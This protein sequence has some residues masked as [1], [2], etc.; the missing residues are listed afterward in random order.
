VNLLP[1]SLLVR[2]TLGQTI[3][4]KQ[5]TVVDWRVDQNGEV[6][7]SGPFYIDLV[8]DDVHVKR[9]AASGF[10]TGFFLRETDWAGLLAD[11]DLDSG[12]HTAKLIVD[13]TDLI[14]E[15]NEADNTVSATFS[16]AGSPRTAPPKT[17]K[18][19]NLAFVPS[20]D[21]PEPIVVAYDR[22]AVRTGTISADVP[23]LLSFGIDNAGVVSI[24]GR[25]IADLYI[26]QKF[27]DRF[28][29]DGM[30]SGQS[31]WVVWDELK[32][33]VTLSPGPHTVRVVAD[34]TS[35]VA[36]TD[37][38]DNTFEVTLVWGAGALPLATPT[39]APTP[40]IPPPR[41]EKTAPDLAPFVPFGWDGAIAARIFDMPG[42]VGVDQP[43]TTDRDAH[44]YFAFRNNSPISAG[45]SFRVVLSVDGQ[46]TWEN[47][48]RGSSADSG[49]VW[50]QK[51][52]VPA[53]KVTAGQHS[54][55][56]LLDADNQIAE[57]DETNN[58]F[59][60]QITWH[61]EAPPASPPP[62]TYTDAEL[63]SL[64]APLAGDLAL[65]T[66]NVGGARK[67][68]TDWTKAVLDIGEAGYYLLTGKSI[69]DE[70][71]EIHVLE[72]DKY[73]AA[74]LASCLS[75]TAPL[76]AA[77]YATRY[78][79]CRVLIGKSAGL[80]TRLDG[81]IHLFVDSEHTPVGVAGTL[82]HELGH[83]Y[84]DI[85]NPAQT[86]AL[87]S[88]TLKSLQE[89]EAQTFEAAAWR[90]VEE[91]LGVQLFRYPQLAAMSLRINRLLDRTV[92]EAAKNEEH[93]LGYLLMWLT[94]LADPGKLGTASALTAATRL[95]ATSTL[96]IF[97]YFV[98]L[99]PADVPAWAGALRANETALAAQYRA[100]VLKRT[101]AGLQ[102][103]QEGHPDLHG[104]AFLAP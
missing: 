47:S 39:P 16:W 18:L 46:A 84:Q 44:I 28:E 41:V 68:K 29:W 32:Q 63:K 7:A 35:S 10:G 53:G 23:A 13:A 97:N 3:T 15:S 75:N 14:R 57:S 4:S 36:E 74:V 79:E 86:E 12:P 26:D 70:R 98:M 77:E 34:P 54:V 85:R 95:N 83:A 52:V 93:Q 69:R 62:V 65:D 80:K 100:L 43:V 92:A 25:V 90:R 94:A 76:I 67:S 30:V 99:M 96:A 19:P 8:L 60:R 11:F 78:E 71:I 21:D 50:G 48:F 9:W 33:T 27:M 49:S 42:A 61:S 37:E 59:T 38:T 81:R 82:L 72:R 5:S 6:A 51:A 64:L 89:A 31:G 20:K 58:L 91:F 104:V 2:T 102:P 103:E 24:Q 88:D 101:E 45:A 55:S 1:T 17:K 56:F 66:G 87:G 40:V 22:I 73:E